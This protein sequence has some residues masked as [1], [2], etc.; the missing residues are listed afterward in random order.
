MDVKISKPH[1]VFGRKRAFFVRFTQVIGRFGVNLLMSV[2][3]CAR[4]TP[5]YPI[6]HHRM[7]SV[8]FYRRFCLAA[9]PC[10]SSGGPPGFSCSSHSPSFHGISRGCRCAA[11][12]L[13][14][15]IAPNNFPFCYRSV[16]SCYG[17]VNDP[18]KPMLQ[19]YDLP[20]RLPA[21]SSPYHNF[22]QERSWT[23]HAPLLW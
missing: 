8:C 14:L 16:K 3:A 17:F 5:A 10:F 4:K 12:I 19:D 18:Q 13:C 20:Y 23:E 21:V 22:T 15:S 6:G 2:R 9:M 11:W 7:R 1:K